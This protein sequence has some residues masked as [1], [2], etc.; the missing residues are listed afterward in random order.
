M[1]HPAIKK[2]VPHKFPSKT[3]IILGFIIGL[4]LLLFVP[5]FSSKAQNNQW[6]DP[7]TIPG[8]DPNSWPPILVADQN[9]TIHAFSSQWINNED[10]DAIRAIV[11]NRWTLENGWTNPTDIILSPRKEA[12]LTDV[13]YDQRG[14]FHLLFFGGDNTAADIYYSKASIGDEN[15]VRKWSYPS[16]IAEK[17]GDP[18]G[19][20]MIEDAQGDFHVIYFGKIYGNGIYE[21]NSEDQGESW[22]MPNPIY[23]ATSDNPNI[24]YISAIQSESGW[25]HVIWGV[26][27]VGGQGRGIYYSKSQDGEVWSEPTILYSATEGYGTQTPAIIEHNGMIFAFSSGISMRISKDNGVTWSDTVKIF[28][29]HTGV[30]GSLSPVIDSENNLHLFFGQRITGNPDIH[31][32]WHSQWLDGRW[33]EPDAVV[34]GP[35]IED[36]IGNKSF[37]PFEATAVV[38]QGNLLFVTWRTDPG[39]P[40]NG[41]WYSFMVLDIPELPIIPNISVKLLEEPQLQISQETPQTTADTESFNS[42]GTLISPGELENKDVSKLQNSTV[43][44]IGFGII[45]SGIFIFAIVIYK[46]YSSKIRS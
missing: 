45:G 13:Y 21:I 12:R 4:L 23:L 17:A 46:I 36:K 15:N 19:A 11:Y 7:Q 34:S 28:P 3:F 10:S 40:G 39:L 20:K 37:D 2:Q 27:N 24:L 18:E 8:F 5:S 42:N 43:Q 25:I 22:S 35:P 14:E 29:R 9:R 44:P 30:N 38:S 6:S 31:G 41:V 32:M 26:Y 1:S 33:T 16:L